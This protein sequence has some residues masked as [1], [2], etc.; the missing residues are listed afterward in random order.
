MKQI[1][2]V[3]L[4]LAILFSLAGCKNQNKIP[5]QPVSGNA[6]DDASYASAAE[7]SPQINPDPGTASEAETSLPEQ[8]FRVVRVTATGSINQLSGFDQEALSWGLVPETMK[9]NRAGGEGALTYDAYGR[10]QTVTW[11]RAQSD[12]TPSSALGEYAYDDNSKLTSFVYS[13]E[14]RENYVIENY[15]EYDERGSLLRDER[16]ETNRD[17]ST[18]L[19]IIE[20]YSYKYD[21]NGR[22]QEKTFCYENY[23]TS[24]DGTNQAIKQQQR[25]VYTFDANGRRLTE[26][27]YLEGSSVPRTTSW[28]YD[29]NGYLI[30]ETEETSG[31]YYERLYTYNELGKRGS[32][33]K[34]TYYFGKLHKSV[35]EEYAYDAQGNRIAETI[36][37]KT[38]YNEER[39]TYR[40]EYDDAGRIITYEEPDGTTEHNEYDQ[41]GNLIRKLV[42]DSN[43]AKKQEGVYTFY[44]NGEKKEAQDTVYDLEIAFGTVKSVRTQYYDEYGN[45]LKYTVT[46]RE[47]VFEIIY[48]YEQF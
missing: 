21:E 3:L 34:N 14:G 25:Y 26:S 42:Y 10:L 44:P 24:A 30:K 13:V 46:E 1:I 2:C 38:E 15:W 43:G 7:G 11:D 41:A 35:E 8:R 6:K 37:E 39:R 19:D 29:E 18:I 32:Y 20:S 28:I 36:V 45:L 12:E 40:W 9:W 31:E 48:E 33:T 23:Q 27:I 5:A 22:I 47:H 16:K 4:S 17:A